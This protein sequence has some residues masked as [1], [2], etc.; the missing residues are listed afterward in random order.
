MHRSRGGD[1]K[2]STRNITLFRRIFLI[3]S[4]IAILLQSVKQFNSYF[5]S[6]SIHVEISISLFKLV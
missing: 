3:S 4:D 2:F 1:G 5:F 6:K